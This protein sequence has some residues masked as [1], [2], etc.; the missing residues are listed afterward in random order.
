MPM[1]ATPYFEWARAVEAMA[2]GCVVISEPS[3]GYEPLVA[4]THFVEAEIDQMAAAIDVSR[5]TTKT[6]APQSPSRPVS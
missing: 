4:G 5:D 2:N 3:E 1:Q 6:V